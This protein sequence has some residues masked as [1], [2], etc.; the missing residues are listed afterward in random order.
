MQCE[1]KVRLYGLDVLRVISMLGIIGLHVLG[2]GGVLGGASGG[3]NYVT[4][5]FV[6]ILVYASV[7]IFAM[8]TGFLN[9]DKKK[10]SSASLIK[11]LLTVA[12]WCIMITVAFFIIKP[13]IF[14]NNKL[15]LVYGVFPPIAGRYWYITSYVLVFF[16]MPYLNCM[17]ENLDKKKHAT[18]LGILFVLLSVFTTF[19]LYEYFK[20]ANGYSPWWLIFCYLIGAYIKKYGNIFGKSKLKKTIILVLNIVALLI[21]STLCRKI[22]GITG[23]LFYSYVSPFTV[24]NSII[25]LEMF[26][27]VTVKEGVFRKVILSLSAV[28]FGVYIIHSHILI[29][30]NLITG[31]FSWVGQLNPILCI[32]SIFGVFAGI[33]AICWL[34]EIIRQMLFKVLFID[35][36]ANVIG[37]KL[38]K[39]LNWN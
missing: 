10:Y 9:V 31:H 36:L 34:L 30:D 6:D 14:M 33:Y 12:F 22:I 25:I 32:L 20:V 2:F 29:F 13:E 4:T 37:E 19:G 8:L 38:N 17:V 28:S 7:N 21:F 26:Y 16:V 39:I 18:L 3:I 15:M 1:R 35:K 5:L 11:L 27:D 23:S 24:V